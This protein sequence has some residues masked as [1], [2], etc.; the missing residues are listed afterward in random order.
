MDSYMYVFK[1]TAK[2][3]VTLKRVAVDPTTKKRTTSEG[4]V[5]S[6]SVDEAKN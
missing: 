1:P 2:G 4:D 6:I 3:K 5:F